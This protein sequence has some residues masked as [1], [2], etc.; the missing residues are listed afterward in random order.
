MEP[1]NFFY[2]S[3]VKS[4]VVRF[5]LSGFTFNS[6]ADLIRCLYFFVVVCEKMGE[7]RAK[8]ISHLSCKNV[9]YIWQL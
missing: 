6:T 4:D 2:R 5:K 3:Q 7:F 1:H 9:N 8:F